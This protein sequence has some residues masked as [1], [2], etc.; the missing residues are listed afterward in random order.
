MNCPL[1]LTFVC[2][3]WHATLFTMSNEGGRGG[4]IS[5]KV[6]ITAEVSK[7]SSFKRLVISFIRATKRL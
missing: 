2:E 1:Q 6:D 3:V 5:D 7:C 4:L